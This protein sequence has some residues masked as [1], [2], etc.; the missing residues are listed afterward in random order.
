LSYLTVVEMT[1]L[2][3][4]YWPFLL[5]SLAIGVGLGWWNRDRRSVD[6]MTAWLEDGPDQR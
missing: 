6:H 4:T 3:G 5:V 1:Y 2:I